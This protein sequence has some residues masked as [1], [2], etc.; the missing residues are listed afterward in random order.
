MDHADG[1]HWDID[2]KSNEVKHWE[3]RPD[4]MEGKGLKWD[5]SWDRDFLSVCDFAQNGDGLNIH[6][7][8][9]D[10]KEKIDSGGENKRALGVPSFNGLMHQWTAE[11][12]KSV[13][14]FGVHFDLIVNKIRLEHQKGLHTKELFSL[15]NDFGYLKETFEA[16]NR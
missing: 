13:T 4:Q 2:F 15:T 14:L 5:A 12:V 7:I 3:F 6:F 11:S 10:L 1:N 16:F 8:Y 9:Q